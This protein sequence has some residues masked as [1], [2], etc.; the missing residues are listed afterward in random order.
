MQR[1][2][3]FLCSCPIAWLV[4]LCTRCGSSFVRPR[5]D[6]QASV[7]CANGA[8]RSTAGLC[9]DGKVPPPENR[10]RA[11]RELIAPDCA[12]G[13]QK[14]KQPAGPWALPPALCSIQRGRQRG[15]V[16]G[17]W[18]WAWRCLTSTLEIVAQSESH[19]QLP[20]FSSPHRAREISRK[21]KGKKVNP[22]RRELM[23]SKWR[24]H[25]AG[26]ATECCAIVLA[27]RP[28][29]NEGAGWLPEPFR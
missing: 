24:F 9:R 2:R 10:G 3:R 25:V 17:R 14:K 4:G 23:N 11:S 29:K 1:C 28:P 22:K 26:G 20:F 7:A 12:D 21:K 5:E 13:G 16:S 27:C 6:R 19:F 8:S 15:Q 18:F